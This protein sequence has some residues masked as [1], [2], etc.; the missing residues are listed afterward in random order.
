[1]SKIDRPTP[2]FWETTVEMLHLLCQIH[3]ADLDSPIHRG[4]TP[5]F[6]E[7]LDLIVQIMHQILSLLG[8]TRILMVVI[9]GETHLLVLA[10]TLPEETIKINTITIILIIGIT[11]MS[12][13]GV[14]NPMPGVMRDT[15]NSTLHL[16]SPQPLH[17]TALSQK[18]LVDLYCRLLRISQRQLM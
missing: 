10:D 8:V 7:E 6:W 4:P 14:H 16:H 5:K 1:M 15:I 17:E 11:S 3:K 2:K 18:H 9:Q 13:R 12:N